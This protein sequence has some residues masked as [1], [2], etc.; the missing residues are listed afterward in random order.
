AIA[1]GGLAGLLAM[2]SVGKDPI[3]SAEA[4]VL[5]AVAAGLLAYQRK[6]EHWAVLTAV[7]TVLASTILVWHLAEANPHRLL[8]TL[9]VDLAVLGVLSLV[10]LSVHRFI[11]QPFVDLTQLR[12][13]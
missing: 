1:G 13:L 7:L 10:W 9:Q 2:L 6:A 8:W 11:T 12:L 3:W 4:I 5:A